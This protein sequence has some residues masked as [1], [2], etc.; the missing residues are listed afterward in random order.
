MEHDYAGQGPIDTKWCYHLTSR[1]AALQIRQGGLSS[2][3]ERSNKTSAK[4]D[5]RGAFAQDRLLKEADKAQGKLI[6]LLVDMC[7]RLEAQ[8][9]MSDRAK[10]IDEVSKLVKEV[11]VH[12]EPWHY[13]ISGDSRLD[14]DKTI[15]L[16]KSRMN[17]YWQALTQGLPLPEPTAPQG[18]GWASGASRHYR[19]HRKIKALAAELLGRQ[20]E[21]FPVRFGREAAQYHYDIEEKV[22]A[23]YVYFF[24]EDQ[25]TQQC[26]ED[27]RKKLNTAALVMLR[28]READLGTQD[29]GKDKSTDKGVEQDM[30]EFRGKKTDKTVPAELLQYLLDHSRFIDPHYRSHPANWRPLSELS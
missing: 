14:Y 18:A 9:R 4:A 27:Y 7:M 5:P 10:V 3:Y 25:H 21:S 29:T 8:A 23:H 26:Y 16:E 6:A 12:Y 22:T 30:A 13:A 24:S 11:D 15:E 2:A 1:E 20:H 19:M 17:S 28:V